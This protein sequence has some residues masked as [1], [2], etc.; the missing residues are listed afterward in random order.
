MGRLSARDTLG[1]AD[2][3]F[4]E[5]DDGRYMTE[6]ELIA[7]R[8]EDLVASV[9]YF[10]SHN[11]QERE[12]WVATEFALNLGLAP[13]Q[14]EL[15][16]IEP[17]PPDVAFRDAR[18]EI[19][20]ILDMGRRRHDEY[21]R[22]LARVRGISKAQDLLTEFTPKDGSVGEIYDLC[23]K[24]AASLDKYSNDLKTQTDL[25]FYVNLH[26]VMYVAEHPFPDTS[27]LTAIGWRSI[28]FLMGRRSC[29]FCARPDA[30]DFFK[31]AVGR[32]CHRP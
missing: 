7:Q 21:K 17:D 23:L 25:L 30:P 19:K 22:E 1:A 26:D 15:R 29:C 31:Q 14:G 10:A 18:F 32:I 8:I 12:R 4:N 13:A 16:S 3:T 24:E 9:A 5:S 28:S 2:R 27:A 11:K 20:E 6:Q